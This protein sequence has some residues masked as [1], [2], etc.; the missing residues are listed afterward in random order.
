[1]PPSRFFATEPPS[2]A[3]SSKPT[4]DETRP[5]FKSVLE[6]AADAMTLLALVDRAEQADW[7]T[8]EQ[9]A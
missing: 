1:M 4:V 6:L 2:S 7:T 3:M 5:T 9:A 8:G